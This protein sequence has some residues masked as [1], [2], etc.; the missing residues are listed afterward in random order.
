MA[1][2]LVDTQMWINEIADI[3][4]TGNEAPLSVTGNSMMPFLRHSRDQVLLKAFSS[5][6]KKGDILL[7]KRK[8]GQY[9]LHRVVK[10]EQNKLWFAGDIQSIVEGPID[11][12]CV[13][14][15]V[16][17]ARRNGKWIQNGDLCW[18]F[19]E[20]VWIRTLPFRHIIVKLYFL[21]RKVF[22]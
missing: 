19:F 3:L 10:C 8:S 1:I 15:K 22:R 5:P 7:Y 17:K 6:A 4:Q 2:R 20:K 18:N 14:A 16:T 9:V 13:I 21:F 11:D 12:S